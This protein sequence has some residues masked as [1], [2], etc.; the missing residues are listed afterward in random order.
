MDGWLCEGHHA[1]ESLRD[2]NVGSVEKPFFG[3]AALALM[4]KV[5][6]G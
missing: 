4:K 5:L 6:C 2:Q 3:M 1:P